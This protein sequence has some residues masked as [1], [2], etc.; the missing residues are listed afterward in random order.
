MEGLREENLFNSNSIAEFIN[1]DCYMISPNHKSH[2]NVQ[3]HSEISSDMVRKIILGHSFVGFEE[4]KVLK[5]KEKPIKISCCYNCKTNV[6]SLWRRIEGNLVCNACALYQ[7]LHG[8]SRPL[9]LCSSVIRKRKRS[10]KK[11]NMPLN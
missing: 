4:V 8:V 5:C 3:L 10:H 9:E 1:E 2:F 7:K 6:T 11:E